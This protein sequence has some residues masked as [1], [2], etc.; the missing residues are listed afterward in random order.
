MKFGP[1]PLEHAEGKI[2]GHN[3]AG[4]DGKRLLRKG[5]PL[6]A[7][8][9]AALRA[10]RRTSVYVAEMEPGDLDEDA[11]ARRVAEAVKGADEGLR[12]PGAASGRANLLATARGVLR[13][14]VERLVRLNSCQGL[15]LATLA[16]HT[17]VRARQIVAT[18]KVIP[19]A[20]PEATVRAAEAIAGES[21]PLLRVDGLNPQNVGLIFSGSV[22]IREKLADDFAPLRERVEALGSQITSTDYVPL[23]DESGEAAL[24]EVLVRQRASGAALVILAGETAIMDRHD[25]VPRAIDRAGGRVE[26]LGVPVDPGNLLMLAY[27]DGVPVLGAPGCARSRKTN[28]VDWVLP[29]LLAGDRLTQADFISL[30]HGGLLEDA[31]ERP[32]PRHKAG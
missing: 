2:L 12:L 11:A 10:L 14:D 1:A 30:G 7:E 6:L 31:P 21:G 32:M 8:D 26:C 3:V 4:E 19:F 15:T 9:I 24:A 20:V 13:V 17:P 27:L 25:I 29:R 18:V 5:K 16:S 23:E 22:S 28:I